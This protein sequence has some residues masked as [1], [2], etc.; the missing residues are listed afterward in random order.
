MVASTGERS[1]RVVLLGKDK[2]VP[3]A[4]LQYLLD[5]GIDVAA[6][7]A[8]MD[9]V[10]RPTGRLGNEA[11]H[12]GIPVKSLDEISEVVKSGSLSVD[13]VL[14]LLYW[15]RIGS[16]LI[17]H[18]RVGCINFHPA[19][20]PEFRGVAVYS[21]GILEE[22]SEW[23][24]SAHF[25]EPTIDTGDLI[26][27]RRFPI[28]ATTHT[29]RS[30]ETRTRPHLLD[31]FKSVVQHLVDNRK[32]SRDPQGSGRY[33]S[34]ADFKEAQQ[35]GPED[36]LET[37]DRKARAFWYPPHTGALLKREGAEYTVVTEEIL[38]EV[39]EAYDVQDDVRETGT[40]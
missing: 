35:I 23:G 7:V 16:E 12:C 22:V 19:P 9:S 6:V 10:G 24:V 31:L 27:V 28:D 8:P 2:R 13:V 36:S 21:F 11:D 15:R 30:L 14:S 4:G 33:Y 3:V 20:L 38:Q 34:M 37:I 5:S 29:A 26:S 1:L 32:L 17:D 25:V 40:R 39:A 18:P